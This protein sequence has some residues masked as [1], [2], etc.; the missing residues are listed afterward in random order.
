VKETLA[1]LRAKHPD[2]KLWAVFEPRSATACRNLHQREYVECWDDADAVLFA[3][4]GRDN[5][6][7][8]ERLNID[9][10]VAGL[11]ARRPALLALKLDSVDAIVAELGGRAAPGDTVALLSNGAF[12]GIHAKLIERLGA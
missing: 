12:G 5:L 1:A 4:L 8:D 9:E 6:A 10:I 11:K 7:S 3:P 2:G